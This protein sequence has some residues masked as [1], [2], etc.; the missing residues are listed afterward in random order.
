MHLP[1]DPEPGE[2]ISVYLYRE[3]SEDPEVVEVPPG[4]VVSDLPRDSHG[5]HGAVR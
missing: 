3:G 4:G 1:T 2:A 5:Y